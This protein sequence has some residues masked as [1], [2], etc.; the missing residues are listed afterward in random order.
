MG[1]MEER[2]PV[3]N[4]MA[5]VRLTQDEDQKFNEYSNKVGVTR[6]K[7]QRKIIRELINNELDLVP[8]EIEVFRDAAKNVAAIGRNFN[9]LI[10][11]INSGKVPDR[12]YHESYFNDIKTHLSLLDTTLRSY[13]EHTEARWTD[14]MDE[15]I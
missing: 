8:E 9:Q 15:E 13:L 6:S 11:A 7:I 10:R 3:K 4:P 12:L 1:K 2:K 14:L 5:R